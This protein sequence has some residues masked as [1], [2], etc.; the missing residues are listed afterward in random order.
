[1]GIMKIVYVITDLLTGGAEMM[2]YKLLSK[3]DK[4][5]FDLA[6]VSLMDRGNLGDRIEALGI[7]VYEIGM[8][9]GTPTVPSIWRFIRLMSQLQPDLL[10]GWM[11]HG[12]LAAQLARGC[13]LKSVPVLWNIRNSLYSLDYEKTGTSAVIQLC[14]KLSD[15][16]QQ[17]IYNSQVSATQ[18]EKIGYRATK[19]SI[20]PNGFD[21]EIFVPSLDAFNSV[22]QELRIPLDTTLIGL[23]GRYAPE[24]DHANFLQAAALLLKKFPQLNV[25][26]V[27]VGSGVDENNQIL[28]R[29]VQELGLIKH[30]HLL[31]EREDIPRLTAALDIASSSSYTEAF[32]NVIGEAMSCAV[33][34]VVTDVGDSARIVGNTGR[35]V[36]PRSPQLLADA[37]KDS[38]DLDVEG[39]KLLGKAARSRII[40]CFSLSAVVS[41]YES[42]YEGVLRQTLN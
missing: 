25:Q 6:V 38:I 8:Q 31:G 15:F 41:Q 36:P 21:T 2:L 1:M 3:I 14:A 4:E 30:T 29:L 7:P 5:R 12:N 9:R 18:H 22:R 13:L 33:P 32:P 26:F 23:I 16:P 20:V 35:I 11:Y 24:K 34:C 27:L 42:L 10:Q 40:E 19:R 28:Y 17:I 39:R 37:W